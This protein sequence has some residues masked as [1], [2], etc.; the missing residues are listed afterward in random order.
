MSPGPFRTARFRCGK[1]LARSILLCSALVEFGANSAAIHAAETA[2][3]PATPVPAPPVAQPSATADSAPAGEGLEE[4]VVNARKRAENAQNIPVV[5]AALSAEQLT[6]YNITS[7]DQVA[8]A[9]PQFIVVH[10]SSG[11]GTN[12]SLRGIGS[13]FTSIGIEQSVAVIMDGVY[14][15]QGRIL[16]EGL[17]DMRQVEVLKGPQ[18]LYFGKNSTAGV[19][20]ITSNDPGDHFEA[21][22]R[23]GYEFT[24]K[25]STVE[26]TLSGPITERLGAR[27]AVR[28][29]NQSDGLLRNQDGASTITV[30]DIGAGNA[31][32]TYPVPASAQ[33]GPG[34][35]SLNARFTA[36]YSPTTDLD[37][38]LKASLGRTRGTGPSWDNELFHCPSG[39]SQLNPRNE[40]R[41]DWK[42]Y[43]DDL[44]AAMVSG[45]PY[46]NEHGGQLYDDYDSHTVTGTVS[47]S[48][49]PIDYSLVSG[50]E[51]F[52]DQFMLKSDAT[53][54]MNRGTFAATDTAYS[55][56]SSELRAQSRLGGPVNFMAGLYYQKSSLD[57]LQDIVFPGSATTG[58]NVDSSV[59][60]PAL[61]MLSLR[62]VG[63]T[64]G[65]TWAG[66]GQVAW[67]IS[68]HLQATAGGRYTSETKDSVFNLPYVQTGLRTVFVNGVRVSGT[69]TQFD[70]T[71]PAA[72]GFTNGQSWSN[73]SPEA[74]LTWRPNDD[75]T[76]YAAYKAGYKSG[77]FSI[78]ALNTFSTT[79][80]NLAFSPE[81]AKGGEV[82]VKSTLL[83]R[84]LRLN[85]AVYD[86]RYTDLQVDFFNSTIPAFVT[87][88]AG[89]AE[90]RG[91]EFDMEWAP[92]IRNL[93]LHAT[94]AYDDAHYVD[95]PGAPC[96]AGQTPAM[97]CLAAT[98]AINYPHQNLAGVTTQLAPKWT[99]S[100]APDYR[101]RLNER[102]ELGIAA[103][104]RY[105]GSYLM[106]PFGN[107]VDRQSA[108]FMEDLS[109]TLGAAEGRWEIALIGK[110]LS[111]EYVLQA[112]QDA[113][114]TGA[115]T[116]TAAGVLADQYGF[117]GSPRT[118]ALRFTLRL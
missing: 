93:L 65:K 50:Y 73:F 94:L 43:W 48:T 54:N 99:A 63:S 106:S 89:T 84:T 20:S 108:Y 53:S 23:G 75:I 38:T 115:G 4:I 110:N 90:T 17:F 88:N 18:A 33:W 66:F 41:G 113:P 34:N 26:G 77:G 2:A 8:S 76:A 24:A 85:A 22:A 79:V 27:L 47:Y 116:G 78:S 16:N 14:Y 37:M 12:L 10:G 83:D 69:Y 13:N 81:K 82:G 39:T 74:T 32:T 45:N 87:F 31:L 56:F 97:G 91:I 19:L 35:D 64:D 42:T 55:A 107:P 105:S 9:T 103:S 70:P 36:K 61:R 44:P 59:A 28:Y 7:I 86:Y 67:D 57:F 58:H 92:P 30:Q 25:E 5:V 109:L 95:F 104:I 102:L 52:G 15:G 3:A 98:P 111:N 11:S 40:C 80:G 49:A 60:D 118:Y 72:T 46:L 114:S 21:I 51:Y 112:A 29:S 71:N 96:Y 117:P 101:I 1:S 100:L 68:Q 62:K 6:R